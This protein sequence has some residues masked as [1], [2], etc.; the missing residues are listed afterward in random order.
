MSTPGPILAGGGDLLAEGLP[1]VGES[2]NGRTLVHGGLAKK[3]GL[4]DGHHLA[5]L[6]RLAYVQ[7][8]RIRSISQPPRW[9]S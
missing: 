6:R 4:F 2:R 3:L 9:N 7:D 5:L 8:R 1:R